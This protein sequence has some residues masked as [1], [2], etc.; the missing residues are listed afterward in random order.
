MAVP[1]VAHVECSAASAGSTY[2]D[3][4]FAHENGKD[5]SVQTS[6]MVEKKEDI[7]KLL[8][9]ADQKAVEETIEYKWQTEVSKVIR[10]LYGADGFTKYRSEML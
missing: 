9:E 6:P 3:S 4:R 2:E 5:H 1:R 10:D 7:M 8:V